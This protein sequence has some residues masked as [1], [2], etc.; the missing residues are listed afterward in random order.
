M[1]TLQPQKEEEHHVRVTMGDNKL[2]CPDATATDTA[3]I[4]TLK[5]LINSV[6][7]TWHARFLTLYIKSYY[8]YTPVSR[9]EY[10]RIPI[11]LI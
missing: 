7:S 10:M 5:L 8:Y 9:Y 6:I 1:A 4:Y 2:D 3:S 11:S